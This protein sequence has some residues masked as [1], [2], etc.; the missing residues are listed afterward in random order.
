MKKLKSIFL[1]WFVM[2]ASL[3]AQDRFLTYPFEQSVNAVITSGWFYSNNCC[4]HA[5]QGAID[6]D[7]TAQGGDVEFMV[8]AAADGEVVKIK[9]SPSPPDPNFG[10]WIALKHTLA[11]GN[12]Y[13]TM[14]AHMAAWPGHLVGDQIK[15][16]QFLGFAWNSGSGGG[17]PVHLHFETRKHVN[18]DPNFQF[19]NLDYTNF[20]PVDPYDKYLKA[21]GYDCD[22]CAQTTQGTAYPSPTNGSSGLM[23]SNYLWTTD[24]PSYPS[25]IIGP[26][27]YS[28]GNFDFDFEARARIHK[29]SIGRPYD[30]GGSAFVHSWGSPP[31]NGV[32]IQDY[33]Q[34]NLSQSHFGTD[35]QSAI[36]LNTTLSQAFLVKEGFW[37]WYKENDG[38]LNAGAPENN[39]YPW[40]NGSRQD[41][42]K[43]WLEWNGSAV[44]PHNKTTG[45]AIPTQQ[46]T[47]N[48]NPTTAEVWH[49]GEK[50]GEGQVSIALYEGFTYEYDIKEV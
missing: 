37:G 22:Q 8:L 38:Y 47:I 24:P 40:G 23:G 42:E 27:Y 33:Y 32:W 7:Q 21:D 10:Y 45:A 16:G 49:N 26:G 6:Y 41:F 34:P 12:I 19:D 25:N 50:Q 17:M 35:G 14:Y 13:Y 15:R 44:V 1:L 46:T 30:N 5:P 31:N 36:I 2:F 3:Q 11:N 28:N 9:Y 4:I 29:F 48:P 18:P 20:P 39:E 43:K